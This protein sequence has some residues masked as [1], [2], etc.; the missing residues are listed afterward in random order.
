VRKI[1]VLQGLAPNDPEHKRRIGAFREGLRELGWVE[2][3]NITLEI[4]YPEGKLDRLPGLAAELVQA[5]VDV[6]VTQGT[7]AAQAARKAT[8]AIP[9]VMAQIGDA[10]GAG[11]IT[12]LARPGGNVTG[13]TLVAPEN[14]TK[15]LQLLKEVM[16][17]ITRVATLWN[18][19]NATGRLQVKEL[20][21]ASR[22][23]GIELQSLDVRES[24]DIEASLQ[25]ATQAKAQALLTID[26]S[27]IQ[28]NRARIVELAMR[29][30]VPVVGE[31]RQL[32][33]AGALLSYSP[34][35]PAM[36]HRA[37]SYV[38]KIFRGAKPADLPVEQPTKFELVINLKTAKALG[39][40]IPQSILLRADEIIQ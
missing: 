27:L 36:W 15:R 23:L 10:V 22:V 19:N 26:D 34:N 37:A 38:D 11:I 39:L 5:N 28:F 32:T 1:G 29:R 7:E 14:I 9:I 31:F 33:E 40:T 8:S 30:G 18:A 2:G 21:T 24:N 13:V 6:L 3:G 12:S 17:G 16:P 4:R 20:A 25:A 35:I